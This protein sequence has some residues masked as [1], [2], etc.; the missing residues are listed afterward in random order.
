[1]QFKDIKNYEDS[2]CVSEFG[3]VFSKDR[4]QGNRVIKSKEMSLVSNGTGYL[5]V[6]LNRNYK[7]KKIYIHRLV[8]ETFKSP[9]PKGYEI[10]HIDSDKSNNKLSNL[11]LFTRKENMAKC[12]KENPH[13]LNNLMQNQNKEPVA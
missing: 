5:Q 8:W 4:F 9:I 6:T 3:R 11:Q 13:V 7:R 2:Y 1:M 12:L 10:D